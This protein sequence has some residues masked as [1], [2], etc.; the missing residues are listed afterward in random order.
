[1]VLSNRQGAQRSNEI[2]AGD[3]L[4]SQPSNKSVGSS[5]VILPRQLSLQ[6]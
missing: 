5:G 4:T 3:T 6:L 1:M 2:I